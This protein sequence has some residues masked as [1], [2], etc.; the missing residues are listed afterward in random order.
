MLFSIASKRRAMP[1]RVEASPPPKEAVE[2]K[3]I[4]HLQPLVKARSSD[5][6]FRFDFCSRDSNG[7]KRT[8]EARPHELSCCTQRGCDEA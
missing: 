2:Q 8:H 1:F 5:P 6:C 3:Y 4:S 7:R